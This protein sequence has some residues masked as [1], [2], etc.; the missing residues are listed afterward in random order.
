MA[1]VVSTPFI[2]LTPFIYVPPFGSASRRLPASMTGC[3]TLPRPK[4]CLWRH[5]RWFGQN[6]G[7]ACF[8]T[9]NLDVCFSSALADEGPW[10][11]QLLL[12]W[13]LSVGCCSLME[14]TH[15]FIE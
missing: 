3:A 15:T 8:D 11:R 14:I 4:V 12:A 13:N 6:P 5:D 7:H 2:I 1:C 9:I 10:S